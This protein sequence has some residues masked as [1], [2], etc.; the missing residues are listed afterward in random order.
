MSADHRTDEYEEIVGL[1]K[2][3][4]KWTRWMALPSVREIL[5]RLVDTD[6]RKAVYELTDGEHTTRSIAGATGVNKGTVSR[7]WREWESQGIV[8]EVPGTRG[9]RGKGFSLLELGLS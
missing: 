4:V 1:L 5:E 8:V 9:K 6:E 2:E 3:L 7:W